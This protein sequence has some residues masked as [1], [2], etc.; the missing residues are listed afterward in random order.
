MSP[1]DATEKAKRRDRLLSEMR[2]AKKELWD[3][4]ERS[5][6]DKETSTKEKVVL[7]GH[8]KKGGKSANERNKA[9]IRSE[10]RLPNSSYMGQLNKIWEKESKILGMNEPE[11]HDDV[12]VKQVQFIEIVRP[13]PKQPDTAS[14]P[15]PPIPPAPVTDAAPP[16]ASGAP[17][18]AAGQP[19]PATTDVAPDV[20]KPQ[21][22]IGKLRIE[23]NR[24]KEVK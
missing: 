12:L 23:V 20:S 1:Q 8:A 5:K 13:A 14:P 18:S 4:W 9:S 3:A 22:D 11:K 6:K 19:A 2:H 15:I 16:P 10:G 21:D 24:P 7:P 17:P